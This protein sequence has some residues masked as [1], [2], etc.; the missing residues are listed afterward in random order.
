MRDLLERIQRLLA[1]G[2]LDAAIALCSAQLPTA[3]AAHE[4]GMAMIALFRGDGAKLHDHATRALELGAGVDACKYLAISHILRGDGEAA[5]EV[6][7][8]AVAI[9]DTPATRAELGTILLAASRPYDA[10]SVLRQAVFERPSDHEARLHLAAA[11]VQ[12]G[13]HTEAISHYARAFVAAPGDHRPIRSLIAMFADLG[14]W[15][16]AGAAVQLAR[17]ES[18]PPAEALVLDLVFVHVGRLISGTYPEPGVNQMADHAIESLA[19]TC[20]ALGPAVQ[21]VVAHTFVELGRLDAA[22]RVVDEVEPTTDDERAA[23]YIVEGALAEAAG[24]H[25]RAIDRYVDAQGASAERTDASI[26]AIALLLRDPSPAARQQIAELLAR[27][28]AERR[29]VDAELMVQEAAYLI[30]AGQLDAARAL[31]QRVTRMTRGA[32][33]IAERA[34]QLLERELAPGREV[35]QPGAFAS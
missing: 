34:R 13:D 25:P 19:T 18:A 11:S 17:T 27:I 30:D 15:L 21:L 12:I 14:K 24:D 5:I 3:P 1:T 35:S 22:R 2:E 26:K 7:H 28:P 29:A 4:L 8:K 9:E 16:G 31:V 10:L 20:K 32:G 33:P 23:R 6:A